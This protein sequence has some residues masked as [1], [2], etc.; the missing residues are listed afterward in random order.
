M[1]N[2][3]VPLELMPSMVTKDRTT[4]CSMYSHAPHETE[5]WRLNFLT[6]EYLDDFYCSITRVINKMT[7]FIITEST[8][9]HVWNGKRGQLNNVYTWFRKLSSLPSTMSI[10]CG[11]IIS[12]CCLNWSDV[13]SSIFLQSTNAEI[14]YC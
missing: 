9:M 10:I 4:K 6:C 11:L 14:T 5:W 3:Y 1:Q 2:N 13:M 12:K 7:L 8:F